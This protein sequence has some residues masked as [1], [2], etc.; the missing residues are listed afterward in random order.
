MLFKIRIKE[1]GN[2]YYDL[3]NKIEREQLYAEIG[4]LKDPFS[5]T[6]EDLITDENWADFDADT[7]LDNVLEVMTELKNFSDEEYKLFINEAK[8][9]IE[10]PID[11]ILNIKNN[12]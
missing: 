3:T 2:R 4:N 8:Q 1:L 10:S 5:Y 9:R 11:I 12:K 7:N 6:V